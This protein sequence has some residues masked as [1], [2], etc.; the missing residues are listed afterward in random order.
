MPKVITTNT[1]G[2]NARHKK[3]R[4]EKV[5][6]KTS[7]VKNLVVIQQKQKKIYSRDSNQIIHEENKFIHYE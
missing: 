5:E 3:K 2:E 4:A 1:P 6:Q 7:S